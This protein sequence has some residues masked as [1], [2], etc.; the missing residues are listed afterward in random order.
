MPDLNIFGLPVGQQPTAL[1][2]CERALVFA[3]R[4]DRPAE[5]HADDLQ[6]LLRAYYA[7]AP[8]ALLVPTNTE[9]GVWAPWAASGL[10]PAK[11]EDCQAG[12][13]GRG[14]GDAPDDRGGASGGG[15]LMKL[16]PHRWAVVERH[17]VYERCPYG[18]GRPQRRAVDRVLSRHKTLGAAEE[19]KRF[20]RARRG[21]VIVRRLTVGERL[22]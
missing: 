17:H 20:S 9:A 5:I 12:R 3:R 18:F 21:E 19:Q 15:G 8:F 11:V 22:P 13:C 16:S 7:G 2:R 10:V 6:M 14:R 4:L 1:E